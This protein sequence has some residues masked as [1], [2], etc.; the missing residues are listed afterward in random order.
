MTEPQ[1]VS[2][3]PEPQSFAARARLALVRSERPVAWVTVA[4]PALGACSAL[5]LL[6]SGIAPPTLLEIG[7]TLALYLITGLGITVGFHRLF[8]HHAF[9]APPAIRLVLGILGSMAA[10]G[11]LFFWAAAHRRHHTGSDRADDPHSPHRKGE[12]RLSRMRGLLHAHVGWMLVPREATG[13]GQIPDLLRDRT[14]FFVNRWYLAWVGLGLA[15][16]AAISGIW[17]GTA[18]AA[19]PGLLWGGLVRIFLVQHA[20]WSVNSLGHVA[21]R[22]SFTT[23]DESRNNALVALI[24]L[25]EGWHNNHHAFPASARHGL[26]RWE[27]DPSWLAI[28][29]LSRFGLTTDIRLPRPEQMEHRRHGRS[30]EVKE[31]MQR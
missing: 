6:L 2:A 16:P 28:R 21:G 3:A 26:G 27:I 13:W 12:A 17:H 4:I 30:S 15:L 22:K 9:A 18:V 29:L 7:V 14:A 19:G 20:T 25:G 1:T 8:T 11:P 24:T 23:R 5:G 31:E 10:Q